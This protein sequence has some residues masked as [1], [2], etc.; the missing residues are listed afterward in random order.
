MSMMKRIRK[1]SCSLQKWLENISET[2]YGP[3]KNR[4]KLFL[5][6]GAQS[7]SHFVNLPTPPPNKLNIKSIDRRD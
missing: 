3:E 7:M 4:N 6:S 5:M 1:T 2:N